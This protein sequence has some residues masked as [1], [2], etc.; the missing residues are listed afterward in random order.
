MTGS[1]GDDCDKTKSVT[2]LSKGTVINHYRIVEKIGAGGMGEV[3]LA[4]DTSLDRQVALKFLPNHLCQD[5]D[6]RARFKREA[7]AV[8]KLDHPNIVSV[9]EVG[10]F[11][12]RPFFAMQHVEGQ[13]LKEAIAGKTLPLDRILEIG[14][15][16]CDGLQA[17]HDKGITHR[18]IKPSNIL[19][20]SHGR[21]RIVDFGLASVLGS[22]PLTKTGSTLGT[23]G[24]MSPEQ[25]R[26]EKVDHRTDLFSLGVVL[27]E[28]IAGHSPFKSESEA[29]TL[30]AITDTKPEPLARFRREMPDG[31]QTIIDKALDKDIATRYQHADELAADLRRCVRQ[32]GEYPSYNESLA[33]RKRFILPV[34]I[35]A[36]VIVVIVA[37]FLWPRHPAVSPATH[38]QITF[39]GNVKC[40]SISPDGKFVAYVFVDSQSNQ[41]LCVQ[42]LAGGEPIT[43]FTAEG[44]DFCVWSR[45]GSE[46]LFREMSESG[47]GFNP[48]TIPR[49][50]GAV[51]D[52]PTFSYASWSP[53]GDRIAYA[54]LMD[55]K[56]FIHNRISGEETEI[57]LSETIRWIQGLDWSPAEQKL[58]VL[59]LQDD[60]CYA[61]WIVGTDGKS[62]KLALPDSTGIS[63]PAWS[64]A[65][66]AIYYLRDQGQTRDLVKVE[67]SGSTDAAKTRET[68]L[69][70]GLQTLDN[71]SISAEGKRLFYTRGYQ[72][73]NLWLTS[74][75]VAGKDTS[76]RTRQLTTGTVSA[77]QPAISPDGK[78]VAFAFGNTQKSN[79]YV[80]PIEGGQAKQLTFFDSFNSCPVWSPDGKEIA[81]GSTQGGTPRVWRL[82]VAGGAPRAFSKTEISFTG[83]VNLTW[84]PCSDILYQRPG[85][86]NYHIL[87]PI[88][89][90]ERPLVTNDSVGWIFWPSCSYDGHRVAVSWSRSDSQ[91]G[92]WVVSLTDSLQKGLE[93]GT[94]GRF[95]VGWSADDRLIYVMSFDPS[96]FTIIPEI[97]T[98]SPNGGEVKP[99]VKIPLDRITSTGNITKGGRKIVFVVAQTLSDAWLV[100]NFDPEVK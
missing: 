82:S 60:G 10:E 88:S 93:T 23:V 71:F 94:S 96:S 80:V 75:E 7:Q 42:D 83:T 29:A 28:L 47:L 17:A 44:I 87:D 61:I 90:E 85:N 55:K 32:S 46:L 98:I 21:A 8:A 53:D 89:E 36:L 72:Y 100:E 57:P 91:G 92:L 16:V 49:L 31:I 39:S 79:I 73:T 69:L 52:L 99:Y 59:S 81:F 70:S 38:R 63:S 48:H 95:T 77:D 33:T 24:Y 78:Q 6:C 40:P 20:D 67:V 37:A 12:G 68:V 9:F 65:G 30:H 1:P 84:E 56:I 74:I 5:A 50:G 26:G 4:E 54:W 11:Q 51:Q 19:I 41:H 15:Q 35:G 27:Y 18:D 13:T 2:V 66:D 43:L 25:V 97:L 22:D 86:R 58:L 64:P 76:V 45:D 62:R 34:S 14:I 3:Y